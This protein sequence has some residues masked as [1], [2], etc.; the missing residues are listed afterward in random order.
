MKLPLLIRATMCTVIIAASSLLMS[1]EGRAKIAF[2]EEMI[3]Q[4]RQKVKVELSLEVVSTYY[5]KIKLRYH[6]IN[7]YDDDLYTKN[8]QEC[9][10]SYRRTSD[11]Q[12]DEKIKT[13][14]IYGSSTDIE[15]SNISRKT[16]YTITP[17]LVIDG[18]TYKGESITVISD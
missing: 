11:P 12:C 15:L 10:V 13:E 17:L 7:Y 14:K 1:C 3:E 6:I 16:S 5:E 2:D 9:A 18:Y 4:K 8:I